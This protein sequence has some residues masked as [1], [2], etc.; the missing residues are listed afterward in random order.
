MTS[1]SA[2]LEPAVL[3]SGRLPAVTPS[4]LR[5][6]MSQFATGVV[7]ITVGG[8]HIHAMTANAF[9]SVSL[10]PPT[11]LC[12]IAHSAVMHKALSSSRS[13]GISILGADQEELARHFADKKRVL[14]HGQFDGVDWQPGEHTRAP[15]LS[16]AL[17]WLECERTAAHDSG[18]HTLFIGTVLAGGRGDGRTDRTGLLFFDG[19][20][21]QPARTR[22]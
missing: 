14:G 6:V 16:G 4:S 1:V 22:T 13:F 8:E 11:I 3:R 15:L 12:S 17:A 20:F 7:V 10:A 19:K 18:D 2:E 5:D 9:S 21:D